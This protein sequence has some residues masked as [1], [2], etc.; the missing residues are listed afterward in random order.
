M[1]QLACP[2]KV[3]AEDGSEAWSA[4]HVH[5]CHVDVGCGR[6]LQPEDYARSY[7]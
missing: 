6:P 5:P 3:Q 4:G 2:R 1:V 7:R